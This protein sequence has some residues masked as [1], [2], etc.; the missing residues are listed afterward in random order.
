MSSA[1]NESTHIESPKDAE[2]EPINVGDL[3]VP[4][5]M[6]TSFRV[7][8]MYFNGEWSLD[9]E[10]FGISHTCPDKCRLY[11]KPTVEDVLRELTTKAWNRG[12]LGMPVAESGVRKLV[13]EYAAK[14]RLAETCYITPHLTCSECGHQ[15]PARNYKYYETYDGRTTYAPLGDYVLDCKKPNY[16]PNCGRKVVDV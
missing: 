12:R 8:Q 14:L 2:G 6:D 7:R 9:L 3:V 15:Y 16:C 10:G 1:T 11:H 4:N 5:G 13:S